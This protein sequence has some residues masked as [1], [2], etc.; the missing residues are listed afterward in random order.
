MAKTHG[1]TLLILGDGDRAVRQ[2]RI[3][4][5]WVLLACA[6]FVS[7]IVYAV[8]ETFLFWAAAAKAR[9]VEPLVAQLREL[10]GSSRRLQEIGAELSEL[11]SFEGQL[12]RALLARFPD[13]LTEPA[14]QPG[15]GMQIGP[16]YRN[17]AMESWTEANIEPS[18]LRGMQE[19]LFTPADLPTYPPVRGYVTRTFQKRGGRMGG[20][21]LGVDIA[22]RSGTPVVAAASGLVIFADWTYL[23]GNLVVLVHRSGY[24]SLYGHNEALLVSPRQQVEQGEP[25]A[26]LGTSGRSSAPHLHYEVWRADEPI[27][28]LTFLAG[29]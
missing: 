10:E 15:L 20:Q 13:T 19:H 2:F 29:E 24:F 5:P 18:F 27:D 3:A 14:S 9:Q 22:A 21:H 25:I 4:R 8:A 17:A 1:W 16:S 12:R 11:K 23:Y 7:L 26:L 6:I 28:P